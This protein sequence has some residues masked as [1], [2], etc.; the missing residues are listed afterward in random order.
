MIG[1]DGVA[2]TN[3][4]T[5]GNPWNPTWIPLAA[6]RARFPPGAPITALKRNDVQEDIFAVGQDGAV[7]TSFVLYDTPNE[8]WG[9]WHDW[10]PIRDTSNRFPDHFTV[11]PRTPVA[12]IRR[13]THQLDIFVTGRDGNAY[14]NFVLDGNPWNPEWIPLGRTPHRPHPR[15]DHHHNPARQPPARHLRDRERRRRLHKLRRDRPRHR[16]L[17]HL[18]TPGSHSAR[19]RPDSSPERRSPP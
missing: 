18:Q 13:D 4:V 19:H 15:R 10:I 5:D 17:G 3:F 6:P 8:R 2:Y 11:P 14:T 7:Y 12:A 9:A 1:R 16:T